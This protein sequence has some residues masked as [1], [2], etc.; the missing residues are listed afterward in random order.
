MTRGTPISG[1]PHILCQC[2]SLTKADSVLHRPEVQSSQWRNQL[3]SGSCHSRPHG[4]PRWNFR[5]VF[6]ARSWESFAVPRSPHHLHSWLSDPFLT[7]NSV[8]SDVQLS[9]PEC[10]AWKVWCFPDE[11]DKTRLGPSLCWIGGVSEAVATDQVVSVLGH[12]ELTS[13]ACASPGWVLLPRSGPSHLG[14][15][16]VP[17]F[18]NQTVGTILQPFKELLW[19]LYACRRVH[20]VSWSK[21]IWAG[22]ARA[23]LEFNQISIGYGDIPKETQSQQGVLGRHTRDPFRPGLIKGWGPIP[24]PQPRWA[25]VLGPIK[26]PWCTA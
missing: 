22:K 11:P 19:W 9:W 24:D 2:S 5:V 25:C 3:E 23:S 1:N 17:P 13:S 21:S 4:I 15:E 14:P 10:M 7:E 16:K 20:D 6:S 12:W 8:S 18:W 26:T